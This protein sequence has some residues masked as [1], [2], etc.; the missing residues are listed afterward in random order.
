M[1]LQSG[2]ADV[3]EFARQSNRNS[4]I[5]ANW[6]WAEYARH[7]GLWDQVI[8]VNPVKLMRNPFYRLFILGKVR[9]LGA[10]LL[11]QPRAARVYLQ[12]DEIAR[13]SGVP[14]RIGNRGTVVHLS[15]FFVWF[16]NR[17]YDRLI[18]V[19]QSSDVHET[20][21][22]DEFVRALTGRLS[23]P[24]NLRK[25]HAVASNNV[26]SVAMGAGEI[27]RVWPMEKYAKLIQHICETR[28][29][30][31][32]LLLGA[33]ADHA[34]AGELEKRIGGNARNVVGKTTLRE[35]VDNLATSGVIICN[36]SSAFHIAMAL[37]KTVI[38]F[39]GGGHFGW[40]APYPAGAVGA[41]KA[42]V[43][44]VPME[45][46]WCN[47]NCEFPRGLGGAFRC[48][49]AISIKMAIDAF[50]AIPDFPNEYREEA[51]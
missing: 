22:N 17:C 9:R 46:F 32:I 4:V 6:A 37:Q 41:A 31:E 8:G 30:C 44:S 24:F 48:V 34:L 19:N 51:S 3:A 26:V 25:M 28:H 49:D 14:M 39:L 40:F 11:V 23:V 35:Y 33:A 45:C 29:S 20:I 43:L 7:L 18:A 1:W 5:V 2:A 50:E 15:A 12:E 13:I 42:T 16:G 10:V 36:D 47:W 21:R 38:C 27:G